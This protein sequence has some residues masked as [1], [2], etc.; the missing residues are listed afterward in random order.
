MDIR[1]LL[2]LRK[3]TQ[4]ISHRYEADLRGHLATLA[5]AFSPLSLF[6]EYVRGGD[7]AAALQSEKAYRELCSRYQA[8][9][10]EKPF[11]LDSRLSAPL[12]L[13]AVTPVL[14]PLEYTHTA[15]N[16]EERHAIRITCPLTWTLSY[17]EA[18]PRR[19][20]A[21]SEGDRNRDES[22]LSHALLQA[23]AL[24]VLVE[25]RKGLGRLFQDLRFPLVLRQ[26]DGLGS[27]PVLTVSAPLQ[28]HLPSDEII[29]QNTQ[30]TGI[31][32]FEEIVDTAA[33]QRLSDPIRKQLL[34]TSR[35]I[36]QTVY[37]N[38]AG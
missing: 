5:P 2:D 15:Q 38:L 27:L 11:S 9:A 19:I 21:L 33:A 37:D 34:D 30:L 25:E 17:P 14:S 3:I 23:L 13:F 31:P 32:S 36:S 1:H 24:A 6:G 26:L 16:G 28:T 35:T 8:V 22:E 10:S 4:A 29:I 20:K 7:K 12:D 18:E